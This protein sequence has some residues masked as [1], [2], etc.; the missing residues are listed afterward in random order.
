M[1]RS[2]KS[3][4]RIREEVPIIE[5]LAD[6]GYDV[7][8][9]G[10]DREQQF[11][12]DLHGDGQDSKPSARVY[13][14]NNQFFCF[15]CGRSRD[16]LALVMEKEA[17]SFWDAIRKIEKRHGLS[18]LP[19]EPD[20]EDATPTPSKAL[21]KALDTTETPEQALLRLDR[22]LQGLTTER[23]LG[24]VKCAGLWEAHD[25]IASL[26]AEGGQDG[27]VVSMSHKVLEA[28]KQALRDQHKR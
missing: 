3:A 4:E 25:R 5:V 10:G 13:P 1:S 24:A 20:E 23:S 17:L 6:Y 26:H 27:T 7:D 21:E 15:A 18:P 8:T 19:W 12:C 11:S 22:F 16:V 2:R 14:D 9:R 28:A